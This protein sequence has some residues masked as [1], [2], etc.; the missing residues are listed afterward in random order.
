[1]SENYHTIKTDAKNKL[2]Y[3]VC[4]AH[5]ITVNQRVMYLHSVTV[6]HA[7]FT[8]IINTTVRLSLQVLFR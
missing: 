5:I 1:M 8:V 4:Y 3:K 7:A 2:K 6:N